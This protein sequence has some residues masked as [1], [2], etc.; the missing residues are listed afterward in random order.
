MAGRATPPEIELDASGLRFAVVAARFH[1]DIT[2][3]LV[4]GAL[5]CFSKHGAPEVPVSWVP[6]AFELPVAC[7]RVATAPVRGF[8]TD[9]ATARKMGARRPVL[10]AVVAVGCVIRGETPHFDFVAGECA[11]GLMSVMTGTGVPI[12]FGVL[13]TEDH[14]QA[15]E[16]SGGAQGNKGWDAALAAIE[17][18]A[19]FPGRG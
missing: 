1:L 17:M 13:T 14:H 6:G 2:E 8:L 16:R 3:R 4:Q 11:R 7:L 9:S 18:G 10:D 5:D 19:V 12:A 15:E